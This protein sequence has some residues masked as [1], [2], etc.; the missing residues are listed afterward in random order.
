MKYE[1]LLTVLRECNDCIC[2]EHCPY[3]EERNNPIRCMTKIVGDA[4]D[5]IE[6]LQKPRWIPVSERLPEEMMRVFIVIK[7]PSY[8]NCLSLKLS[9]GWYD[10]E[11]WNDSFATR[12]TVTHWMPLPEPPKEG[13]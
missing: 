6:E 3:H 11:Y 10:G 1:E 7:R 8:T 5:A 2:D 9:I 13:E 4:A 12:Y